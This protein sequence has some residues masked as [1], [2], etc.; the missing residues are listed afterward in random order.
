[1]AGCI[2]E[3]YRGILKGLIDAGVNKETTMAVL[4]YIP[5]CKEQTIP[6]PA[7]KSTRQLAEAWGIKPVYVDAEGKREE[8]SSPSALIKFLGLPMSGS[9]CDAE[10]KTCRA[11]SAVDIL[12]ISG[13][14]VSGDGEPRKASEGGTKLT[15]FHPEA[16]E[17]PKKRK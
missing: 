1:M 14:T 3:D 11:T 13:Y 4:E 17:M 2:T 15:V 8:F 7:R 5:E 12:R 9:V 6:G 16:P 10:G